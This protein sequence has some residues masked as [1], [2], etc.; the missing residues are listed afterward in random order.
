MTRRLF[1]ALG[2]LSLAVPALFLGSRTGGTELA[3]DGSQLLQDSDGDFLPDL[4]EWTVLANPTRA[5]TDGD[6]SGDFVE[7]VQHGLPWQRDPARPA[8]HEMRIVVTS[9]VD[10]SGESQIW[11]HTLLRLMGDES[12]VQS[13]RP[14]IQSE[15]LPGLRLPLGPAWW[16][17][18]QVA[19]RRAGG[20]GL[21]YRVSVHLAPEAVLR[22]FLPLTIAAHATLGGRAVKSGAHLFPTVSGLATLVP[23]SGGL[24]PQTLSPPRE[25]ASHG[26]LA[27]KYCL[28]EVEEMGGGPGGRVYEVTSADC[29]NANDLECAV[30]CTKSQGWVFILP[31]GIGTVTGG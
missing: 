1:T 22:P 30:N 31:D 14:W 11:M 24:V 2:A 3:A 9:H 4:L 8:D 20:E 23:A 21:W 12:V 29:E 13:Y 26:G 15:L 5:D 18:V 16:R 27:N 10:A 25:S 6:G 19:S 28:M 17:E 7:V